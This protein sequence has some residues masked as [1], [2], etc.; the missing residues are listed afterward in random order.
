MRAAILVR[1]NSPL[2]VEEV[3]V[4]ELAVGQVLVKIAASGVC[5]KQIDEL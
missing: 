5:G 4:P 1:Q 2:V 3:E